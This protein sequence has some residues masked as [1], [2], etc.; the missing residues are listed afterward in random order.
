ME[1]REIDFSVDGVY[2]LFDPARISRVRS[3]IVRENGAIALDQ[4]RRDRLAI[5]QS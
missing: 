3:I 2:C 5:R 1:R 4:K